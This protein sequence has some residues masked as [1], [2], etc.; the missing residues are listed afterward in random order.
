[1]PIFLDHHS[2]TPLD[3]RVAEAMAPYWSE[4]FGNPHSAD[5]RHGWRAQEAVEAARQQV[6][7]LIGAE[8]AEI[9]FTSGATEANNLAIHGLARASAKRHLVAAMG[10][11]PCVHESVLALAAEGWLV[12]WVPLQDDGRV[13]PA[14]VAARL[15]PD[16]SMVTI[17][18]ANHEIGAL[19][20]IEEIAALCAARAIPF[21]TDAAQAA[22]KVPVGVAGVAL[23][24]LS[25]HKLHGPKGIGALYVRRGTILKPL[26]HGGGQ[27]GGLRPGTLPVPLIVGFGAAC[28]LPAEAERIAGLRDRMLARLRAG[29][30]DL[31]VNGGLAH[32]LP[33]NLNIAV[34]G[35]PAEDL[36]WELRDLISLS[37]GSACASAEQVPSRILLAIGQSEEQAREGV[38]IGIGRDNDGGEIDAAADAI[39]AA[40][41]ELTR[42]GLA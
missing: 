42:S 5:H 26:F 7:S 4:H 38:R 36:L 10:E 16:T 12:D 23:M 17:S 39:L 27:E 9:V 34:P 18:A 32:R 1:M 8:P 25:A 40:V 37:A 35:L 15:G 19:Q 14:E 30:P 29:L 31:R 11:H 2:T 33:G 24:S 28:G 41:H 3:P 20:P 22:G 6:A 21:H 13:D